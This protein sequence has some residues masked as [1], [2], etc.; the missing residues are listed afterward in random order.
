VIS[1]LLANIA[2]HGLEETFV[3]AFPGR[4]P[5]NRSRE[6]WAPV[7]VRYADDFVVLHQ[8]RGVVEQAQQIA[9]DW[10][11]GMGLDLKPEK[12]RIGHTLHA[13]GGRPGF[14][15]LG[16]TVRQFPVGKYR[17]GKSPQGERLGFKT[18]I[19]P[20]KEACLAHQRKLKATVRRY[21]SAPQ[22]RLIFELNAIVRGWSA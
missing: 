19:K 17:T 13:E 6:R 12:T 9:R 21:R 18:I 15:F 22:D 3:S 11:G 8:D 2:L 20:S 5:R 4:L 10:L 7:V 1:P 14:D 16:F